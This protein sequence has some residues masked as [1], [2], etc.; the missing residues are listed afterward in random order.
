[1]KRMANDVSFYNFLNTTTLPL[2]CTINTNNILYP[3]PTL[4]NTAAKIDVKV[5]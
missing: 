4:I 2:I 1:M 5:E 3:P